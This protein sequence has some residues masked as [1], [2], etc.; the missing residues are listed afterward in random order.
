[1]KS[2]RVMFHQLF[3]KLNGTAASPK[4]Q[5]KAAASTPQ[6]VQKSKATSSK[7]GRKKKP[8]SDEVASDAAGEDPVQKAGS[9]TLEDPVE[10]I[11]KEI[12]DDGESRYPA[13]RY[14]SDL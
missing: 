1:M 3:K 13:G 8:V 12:N 10:T 2:T 11:N 14:S 5:E 9:E 6:G 7:G 4:G